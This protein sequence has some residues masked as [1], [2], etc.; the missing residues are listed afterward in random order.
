MKEKKRY[1]AYCSTCDANVLVTLEEGER[2]LDPSK[3]ECLDEGEDCALEQCPLAG[4]TPEELAAR[5]EFVPVPS[6][7]DSP[8]DLDEAE[9][10]VEKA[11]IASFRRQFRR[12]D[13]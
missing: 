5:L 8:H 7:D 10:V 6:G 4:A 9:E 12:R 13:G 2:T 11:R 3:V 1:A